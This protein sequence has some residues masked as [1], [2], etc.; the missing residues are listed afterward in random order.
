MTGVAGVQSESFRI[1]A[2][3][4]LYYVKP[5]I[6]LVRGGLSAV[7]ASEYAEIYS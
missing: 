2:E 4:R 6:D 5:D 1:F 3:H 7:P